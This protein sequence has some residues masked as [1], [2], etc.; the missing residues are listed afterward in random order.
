M[1]HATSIGLEYVTR[2]DLGRLDAARVK[3]LVLLDAKFW[4]CTLTQ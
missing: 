4:K 1:T 3:S 2:A